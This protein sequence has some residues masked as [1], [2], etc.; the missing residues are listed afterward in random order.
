MSG[1]GVVSPYR[2]LGGND[3]SV[4]VAG[5]GRLAEVGGH[6][7]GTHWRVRCAGDAAGR[8]AQVLSEI[9]A[10]FEREIGLMSQWRAG[11]WVDRYNRAPAGSRHEVPADLAELLDRAL[12]IAEQTE[13]AFDPAIG[14]L[15]ECWGFGAARRR[16]HPPDPADIDAARELGGWQRLRDARLPGWGV[17]SRRLLQPGGLLLDLSG[18]G[19]GFAVDRLA[20][21]LAELG[22][23]NCLVE[24]GGEWRACGHRAD[25]SPWRVG[26]EGMPPDLNGRSFSVALHDASIATSGDAWHAFEH[27]G[28]RFGHTIDPRSGWPASTRVRSASVVATDCAMADALATALLVLGPDQGLAFAAAHDI[29]AVFV[30]GDGTPASCSPGFERLLRARR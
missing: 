22:F 11:S 18:I 9:E 21:R 26:I 25:G 14:A 27:Q 28:R 20:W 30:M 12:R 15:V 2:T 7:M 8:L 4:G 1:Y 29:A 16:S 6:T 5:A 13:G 10:V 17:D 19:K 23:A 3:A 24:I